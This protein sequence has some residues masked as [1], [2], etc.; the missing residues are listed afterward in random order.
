MS[1]SLREELR[2]VLYPQQVLLLRIAREFTR[3]GLSR[4]V[5]EQRAVTCADAAVGDFPWSAALATL[6]TE[7]SGLAH[8]TAFATVIL[9]DHFMRYALVPWSGELRDAEEEAA[10]ARYHFRRAYGAAAESWELRLSPDRPGS[11]QLASAADGTLTDAVRTSFAGAG[12]KLRSIQPSLMAAYNCCRSRL[13]GSNAWFVLFETGSLCIALLQQGRWGSVR[14]LRADDDW[15][16]ALP[17]LLERESYLCD[18]DAAVDDIFLWAPELEEA[19]LPASP[20]LNIHALQPVLQPGF[21]PEYDRRF[22]IAM[23]G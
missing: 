3:R 17:L 21:M 8:S 23:G 13:Q 22:A 15:R 5:L 12:I 14:K 9:S 7:L 16:D 10:L 11:A 2:V 18:K 20:R 6:R 1:L 19:S 4:R